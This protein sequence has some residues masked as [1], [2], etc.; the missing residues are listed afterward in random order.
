MGLS[1]DTI[2]TAIGNANVGQAIGSFDGPD[3]TETLA[4]SDRLSTPE[5]FASIVVR[6]RNGTVVK[7][8]DVATV[9]RGNKSRRAAGWYNK[10]PS[11]LLIVT[12]QPKA[13][14]IDTVDRVK[15]LLPE[16]QAAGCRPASTSRSSPT[17]P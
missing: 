14:V 4:T 12:K 11:V 16:L 7:L 13:N 17:G 9:E 10:R 8:G 15:A 2:R 5:D 3:L 6:A 1:I